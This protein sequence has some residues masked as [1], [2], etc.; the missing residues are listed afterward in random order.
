MTHLGDQRVLNDD[1]LLECTVSVVEESLVQA[2]GVPLSAPHCSIIVMSAD[3]HFVP[4]GDAGHTR[5]DLRNDAGGVAAH[6]R[7]V[8]LDEEVQRLDLPVN[9][10]KGGRA[11]LDEYLA[12]AGLWDVRFS[13]DELAMGLS[14]VQ[15]FLLGGHRSKPVRSWVLLGQG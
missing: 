9:R 7:G 4:D 12:G 1:V 13:D 15:N 3:A 10:V 11:Y 14:E 6:D 5:A 8:L 2:G